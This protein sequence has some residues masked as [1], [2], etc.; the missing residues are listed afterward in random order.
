M[1]HDDVLDDDDQ[2]NGE[3]KC[4]PLGPV[5]GRGVGVPT[6]PVHPP[7]DGPIEL[8]PRAD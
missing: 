7:G 4:G 6:H 5:E 2:K 8:L 3:T 1:N